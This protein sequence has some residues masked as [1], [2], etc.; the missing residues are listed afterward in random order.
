MGLFVT[1]TK[2]RSEFGPILSEFLAGDPPN[3][4]CSRAFL[5]G[6]GALPSLQCGTDGA[7]GK[8]A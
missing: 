7:P 3:G 6:M 1:R 8:A 4:L 2:N 5:H